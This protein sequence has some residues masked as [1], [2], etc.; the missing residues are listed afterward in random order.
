MKT[1]ICG[2]EIEV[3][4]SKL[5]N[6]KGEGQIIICDKN[7]KSIALHLFQNLG[8]IYMNTCYKKEFEIDYMNSRDMGIVMIEG[9]EAGD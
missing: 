8:A 2:F 9:F 6:E 4:K 7:G 3:K 1:K 5:P